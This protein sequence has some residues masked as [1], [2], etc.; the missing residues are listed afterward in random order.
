M[1]F[2][3]FLL[4]SL[5]GCICCLLAAGPTPMQ[6]FC[7]ADGLSQSSVYCILQDRHGFWWVGTADGLNRFDGREFAIFRHRPG[8]PGSLGDN[9]IRCL[10]EARDGTLWVGTDDGLF[11]YDEFADTFH[12]FAGDSTPAGVIRLR[13]ITARGEDAAGR[14]WIGTPEGI[15]ISDI[16]RTRLVDPATVFPAHPHALDMVPRS[17]D[18]RV[19]TRR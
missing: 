10:L 19:S 15:R 6:H 17:G 18:W 13:H 5:A 4:F 14:L 2:R 8:R 11:R 9:T 1:R 12:P 7:V 3:V 16:S